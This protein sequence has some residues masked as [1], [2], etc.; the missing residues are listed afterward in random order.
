MATC[1]LAY[2]TFFEALA[3]RKQAF[4]NLPFLL[5]PPSGNIRENPG[6]GKWRIGVVSTCICRARNS[7]LLVPS[8]DLRLCVLLLIFLTP[9]FRGRRGRASEFRLQTDLCRPAAVPT[10]PR[11]LLLSEL[12]NGGVVAASWFADSTFSLT[13]FSEFSFETLAKRKQAVSNLAVGA[14]STWV[15]WVANNQMLLVVVVAD[16]SN[17]GI[18]CCLRHPYNILYSSLA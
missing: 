5:D 1:W 4:L 18:A 6:A 16:Y 7:T 9:K 10:L 3:K 12:E 13:S 17:T 11:P 2:F 14:W 8:V 15:C